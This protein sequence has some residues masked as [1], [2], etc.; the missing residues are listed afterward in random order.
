MHAPRR[1]KSCLAT[2][3]IFC[4]VTS[5]IWGQC[6]ILLSRPPRCEKDTLTLSKVPARHLHCRSASQSGIRAPKRSLPHCRYTKNKGLE[7]R[8]SEPR[9]SEPAPEPA[10]FSTRRRRSRRSCSSSRSIAAFPRETRR[11]ASLTRPSTSVL[12]EKRDRPLPARASHDPL[13]QIAAETNGAILA[14]TSV[15]EE[16]IR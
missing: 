16:E 6:K 2:I 1:G 10:P 3:A 12:A 9:K 8:K 7:S 4:R 15:T 13:P 11:I 5:E 14:K